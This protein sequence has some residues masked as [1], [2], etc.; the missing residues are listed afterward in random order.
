MIV[1]KDNLL[2]HLAALTRLTGDAND[3]EALMREVCRVPEHIVDFRYI[4]GGD[5]T[6]EFHEGA[7]TSK[8]MMYW[9][10]YWDVE[11]VINKAREIMTGRFSMRS[12]FVE[13]NLVKP[14][15]RG[16]MSALR[17]VTLTPDAERIASE[18]SFSTIVEM[19]DTIVDDRMRESD[20][21]LRRTDE[22]GAS[23]Q[24][25]VKR[26]NDELGFRI[27]PASMATT[28]GSISMAIEVL[29]SPADSFVPPIISDADISSLI[30]TW[31]PFTVVVNGVER[32]LLPLSYAEMQAQ[33]AR[34]MALC[35]SAEATKIAISNLIV[36]LES[37][38]DFVDYLESL[39]L[40][41]STTSAWREMQG[42]FLTETQAT[43]SNECEENLAIYVIVFANSKHAIAIGASVLLNWCFEFKKLELSNLDVVKAFSVLTNKI[44]GTS[45]FGPARSN[46]YS[47][48]LATYLIS[49]YNALYA[50]GD[51]P[52][53]WVEGNRKGFLTRVASIIPT[54]GLSS[55]DLFASGV[56]FWRYI[57]THGRAGFVALVFAQ[58]THLDKGSV[59]SFLSSKH[60]TFPDLTQPRS[61]KT[62]SEILD[63]A[64]MHPKE[65]R[66]PFRF[67]DLVRAIDILV[68]GTM[69]RNQT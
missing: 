64:I 5:P 66:E 45:S 55:D 54:I 58:I 53:A 67:R 57:F 56:E 21:R 32:K 39:R 59:V 42:Q 25:V 2:A 14:R 28:D 8:P 47:T 69:K 68:S 40:I 17:K 65:G 6:R 13:E 50:V 4:K 31:E 7:L 52:E 46:E 11:I 44:V 63:T 9:C 33:L 3:D 19:I 37:Q 27:I 15:A 29:G 60:M 48:T 26:L 10:G 34:F 38:P 18:V 43:W 1:A 16:M 12:G 24:N 49:A 20:E 30:D 35:P 62:A 22:F 36:C 51:P 23:R 61:T 41:Q